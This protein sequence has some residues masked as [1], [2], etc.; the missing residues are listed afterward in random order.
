VLFGIAAA[1]AGCEVALGLNDAERAPPPLRLP[2]NDATTPTLAEASVNGP[3]DAADAT[4]SPVLDSGPPEFND[5]QFV[6]SSKQH[7]SCAVNP[8]MQAF[9]WGDNS[10]GQVGDGTKNQANAPVHIADNVIDIAAGYTHSCMVLG[11]DAGDLYCWGK[12]DRG[13]LGDATK[14]NRYVPMGK[15]SMSGA[16]KVGV[17]GWHTCAL[18]KLQGVR[19]W[20]DNYYGALGDGTFNASTVYV[21]VKNLSQVTSLAVG[22]MHNCASTQQG[23]VYCW[24]RAVFGEVGYAVDG[25]NGSPDPGDYGS[26]NATEVPGLSDIVEV[27]AGED[28][29]CAIRGTD[30]A[31][32]CWGRNDYA[33]FGDALKGG[34]HTTPARTV[35]VGSDGGDKPYPPYPVHLTAG[36]FSTCG[37]FSGGQVRCWGENNYGQLGNGDTVPGP[38]VPSPY[39]KGLKDI[40]DLATNEHTCGWRRG[41]QTMFCWGRNDLGQLGIGYASDAGYELLPQ[42]VK[43]PSSTP[44]IDP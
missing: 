9:C 25:N 23:K 16:V 17:G 33:Q 12:N 31:I 39:I 20:G 4:A 22:V 3:V 5:S 14:D 11:N 37:V 41:D 36:K 2:P 29:T 30:G 15:L 28:H 26:P 10:E 42:E 32:L 44:Q 27:V 19:C 13:E 40:V 18:T 43:F 38:Y 21:D 35:D 34:G 8:N 1:V 6:I 24:G 7:H